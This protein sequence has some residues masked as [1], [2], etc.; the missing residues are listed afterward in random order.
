MS[1]TPS[2]TPQSRPPASDAPFRYGAT[3]AN[4]IEQR[5]Q[6]RW[7]ESNAFHT[8]NPGDEGFDPDQAKFYCLDMFPYPSGAGLHVGHPVGYVGSDIISRYRRMKGDN[9][10]HPMGWDAF[11]LPAEQYAIATGVHPAETT[12]T[13]IDTYRRQLQSFGFSYDWSREFATIDDDY[14]HWT[15]WI[16]LQAWNA[17]YDEVEDRARP[18]DTLVAMLENND[19]SIDC[20]NE[21]IL[22][23][24]GNG[25]TGWSDLDALTQEAALDTRRMAYLAHQTVNWCPMLGT[26]LANEE[27]IDGRSERGGHPVVRRPL[28][29]CMF[30][31]TAFAHR[32]LEDLKDLDWPEST[33]AQQSEWIGR[34]EG[35]EL[36]FCV[37][38]RDD[39][40]EVFTTRPDTIFGATFM[41]LAP[42]HPLVETVLQDSGDGALRAYVEASRNRADVDRMADSKEKTGVP[43][44]VDAINPATGQSIPIWVADYVLAHYRSFPFEPTVVLKAIAYSWGRF[45]AAGGEGEIH[46][47]LGLE[48]NSESH[49]AAFYGVKGVALGYALLLRL[50]GL[51]GMFEMAR[52][53][54]WGLLLLCVGMVL[55]FMAGTALVG[56]PRYRLSVEPQLM[57]LATFGFAFC[58]AKTRDWRRSKFSNQ[59]SIQS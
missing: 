13:A 27:V 34:S 51:I 43:L 25:R 4:D 19:A 57:V 38:G 16:W 48:G 52:R 40:I 23:P 10:L 6:Q 9:V 8:L 15:Q 47:L 49:T 39:C 32:L 46:R 36:R 17:W 26:V 7:L 24:K 14:Y 28:Q 29:Q 41:V 22:A 33:R 31:I 2:S 37:V 11:G 53:G 3:L 56:Q 44:G 50:M 45:L 20:H 55:V 1:E 5:W 21:V 54:H 12:S 58:V 59:E 35:A 18:I 30:R 42:E